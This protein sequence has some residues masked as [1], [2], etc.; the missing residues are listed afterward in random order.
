MF[1][2]I[3]TAY[4]TESIDNILAKWGSAR[5]AQ[6]ANVKSKKPVTEAKG[7][8]LDAIGRLRRRRR[9]R[10]YTGFGIAG[11]APLKTGWA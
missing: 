2:A 10:R 8:E 1:R 4:M 6:S 11:S 9:N 7:A 3:Q 5:E